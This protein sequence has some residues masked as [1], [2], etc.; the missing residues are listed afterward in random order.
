MYLR[1]TEDPKVGEVY[2]KDN[3]GEANLEHLREFATDKMQALLEIAA[4]EGMTEE[5]ILKLAVSCRTEAEATG[6][7]I[8]HNSL[9]TVPVKGYVVDLHEIAGKINTKKHKSLFKGFTKM[10]TPE[11]VKDVLDKSYAEDDGK[12][13]L[14]ANFDTWE[15]CVDED[16]FKTK[17]VKKLGVKEKEM[18]LENPI[19]A[20][21]KAA[22]K[23]KNPRF[24]K[25][26]V[27][28]KLGKL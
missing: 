7:G 9:L 16:E 20:E 13:Y 4:D 17:M 15:S 1:E 6:G 5:E 24:R 28:K 26:D 14:E 25:S 27:M 12:M 10:L 8:S 2:I 3:I 21:I 23:G 18:V 22:F 11:Q 19:V